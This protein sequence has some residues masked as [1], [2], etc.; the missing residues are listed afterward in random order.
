[1]KTPINNTDSKMITLANGEKAV[2]LSPDLNSDRTKAIV[3]LDVIKRLAA[4]LPK[5]NVGIIMRT[6]ASE[7]E[8]ASYANP[9]MEMFT[10]MLQEEL[11]FHTS[12]NLI[13]EYDSNTISAK[14]VP[15]Y[16]VED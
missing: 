4:L 14:D 16:K 15:S 12:V 13:K 2:N 11:A 7:I 10:N 9:T 5:A 8:T 6:F 1:M 3:D